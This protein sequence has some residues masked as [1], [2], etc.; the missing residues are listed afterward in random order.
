MLWGRLSPSTPHAVNT[1]LYVPPVLH[2]THTSSSS[3][4]EYGSSAGFPSSAGVNDR[5]AGVQGYLGASGDGGEGGDGGGGG[6]H[7]HGG[8]GV[9]L[10]D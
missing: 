2:T 1:L 8:A 4:C 9:G 6:G 5:V 3:R 7:G 10:G